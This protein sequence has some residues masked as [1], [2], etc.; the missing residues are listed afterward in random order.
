MK[1]LFTT[2]QVQLSSRPPYPSKG[3]FPSIRRRPGIARQLKVSI[4]GIVFV[5]IHIILVVPSHFREGFLYRCIA[6]L[7]ALHL[8]C[9][10]LGAFLVLR[11]RKRYL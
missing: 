2:A 7:V 8:D 11:I 3:L 6:I 1:E 10:L 4:I 9:P 5:V